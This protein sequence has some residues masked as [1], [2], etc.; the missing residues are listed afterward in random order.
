MSSNSFIKVKV[1]YADLEVAN[2]GMIN[3]PEKDKLI[4]TG[5]VT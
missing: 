5:N 3:C 2:A 1:P 4:V